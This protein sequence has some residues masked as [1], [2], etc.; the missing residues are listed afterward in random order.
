MKACIILKCDG[1]QDNGFV[2]CSGVS[3]VVLDLEK[4]QNTANYLDLIKYLDKVPKI[5]DK[6]CFKHHIIANAIYKI[7]E[8]G[9]I[10]DEIYKYIAHFYQMHGHCGLI[11]LCVPK[12]S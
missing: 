3:N 8:M 5:F 11:L 9:Y 7:Y 1:R 4:I 2:F 10:S 6:P 12:E